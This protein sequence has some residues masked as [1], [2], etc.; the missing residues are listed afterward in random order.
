MLSTVEESAY[1]LVLIL[2]MVAMEEKLVPSVDL[3]TLYCLNAADGG[4]A[5][6]FQATNNR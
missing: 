6:T 2:V 5:A 1:E 3:I 4:V